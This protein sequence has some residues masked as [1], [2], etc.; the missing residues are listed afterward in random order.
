MR[1]VLLFP[2][3][4][5]ILLRMKA[6]GW[7]KERIIIIL[8]LASLKEQLIM[9][10]NLSLSVGQT[11]L[12]TSLHMTAGSTA[13]KVAQKKPGNLTESNAPARSL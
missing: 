5:I 2:K 13:E 3:Q 7:R 11:I 8:H 9:T 12:I 4:G 10:K 1:Q 6:S